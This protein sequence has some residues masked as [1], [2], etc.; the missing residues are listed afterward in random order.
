M[1]ASRGASYIVLTDTVSDQ[2]DTEQECRPFFVDLSKL[3]ARQKQHLQRVG[4]L[5]YA[6]GGEDDSKDNFNVKLLR[7]KHTEYLKQPFVSSLHSS[8]VSLDSS[9][10][11]II[12]WCLHGL[13]LLGHNFAKDDLDRIIGTLRSCLTFSGDGEAGFGGGPGQLAHCAPNYA[14]VL[15][16]CIIGGQCQGSAD[17]AAAY[18]AIDRKALY[19]WFLSLRQDYSITLPNG[20]VVK[21]V[22]YRMHHDGE[23]DVR[24]T[25]TVLCIAKLLNIL[26]EELCAGVAEYVASC[27]TY[28][29]GFGAEFSNEAH[30]GY[31]YCAVAGLFLLNQLDLCDVSALRNYLARMQMK[32]EGGFCGR[33]N[34]LVDGCYTFW[35]GGAVAILNVWDSSRGKDLNTDFVGISSGLIEQILEISGSDDEIDLDEVQRIDENDGNEGGLMFNQGLLQRYTML[36]AQSVD[37]GLRDKPSKPRDFYHSC[38][39]LSGLSVAQHV[40]SENGVP[41]VYGDNRNLLKATHPIFNIQ[42]SHAEAAIN[43]FGK[44]KCMD[45]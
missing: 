35:Q 33:T 40:L 1:F 3:P 29:G 27:Q 8:F 19:T 42:T 39:N 45:T 17:A 22:G 21:R 6:N 7:E 24:G 4:L 44:L 43:Y 2:L 32:Y 34:K 16:L 11:W 13:D 37:G 5:E 12:Y 30:G 14:A 18:E 25:Y 28:E 23:V 36:C 15:A 26:T 20:K 41:L 31:T 38:Y 10:P 9:R